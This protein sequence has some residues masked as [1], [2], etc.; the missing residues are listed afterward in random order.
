MFYIYEVLYVGLRVGIRE[1][2][3]GLRFHMIIGKLQ[4]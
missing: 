4:G 3:N 1:Y 2:A